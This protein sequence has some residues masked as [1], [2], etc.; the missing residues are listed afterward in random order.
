MRAGPIHHVAIVVRSIDEALPRYR[1]FFGLEAEGEPFVFASQRVRLCFVATGPAPAA[2]IELVEPIDGDSGVAR[3]L[4]QRGEGL[5]HVC[6]QTDDLP[7][8]LDELAAQEAELI[9]R[10][11]RAGAHGDVAFVHPR[12]L[13]GVLWELLSTDGDRGTTS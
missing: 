9:D 12:A 1:S 5:H 8:A 7:R 11:P 6:L 10:E 13:N 4:A 3:F 2:R